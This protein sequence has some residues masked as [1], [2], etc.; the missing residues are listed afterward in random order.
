MNAAM[1]CRLLVWVSFLTLCLV[2]AQTHAKVQSASQNSESGLTIIPAAV[3]TM[4]RSCWVF[5][6]N[7]CRLPRPAKPFIAFLCLQVYNRRSEGCNIFGVLRGERVDLETTTT[8]SAIDAQGWL[9]FSDKTALHV[10]FVQITA[11]IH[12]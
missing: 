5:S 11:D 9:V 2:P 1:T 7:A 6:A 8:V 10:L 4:P 12:H 3:L